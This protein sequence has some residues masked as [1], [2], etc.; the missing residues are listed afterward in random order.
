MDDLLH[1]EDFQKAVLSHNLQN[2]KDAIQ[3]RTLRGYLLK[4]KISKNTLNDLLSQFG[5]KGEKINDMEIFL[6]DYYHFDNFSDLLYDAKFQDIIRSGSLKEFLTS[7][8]Q[9][10]FD[11]DNIC[12]K[13]KSIKGM[14][15]DKNILCE[16]VFK[17]GFKLTDK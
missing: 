11:R 8:N 10:R 3:S 14:I 12:R 9:P 6:I 2:F 15:I 1:N 5:F 13:L 16:I 17:I 7:K 4:N